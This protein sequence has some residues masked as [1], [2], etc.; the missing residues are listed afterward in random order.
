MRCQVSSK[1]EAEVLIPLSLALYRLATE[2]RPLAAEEKIV[3]V[4]A[5]ARKRKRRFFLPLI[6]SLGIS[7]MRLYAANIDRL[8]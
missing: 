3:L 8:H 1:R 6:A 7:G 2:P 4:A 5:G